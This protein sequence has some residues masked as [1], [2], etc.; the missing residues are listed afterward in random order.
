MATTDNYSNYLRD[1]VNDLVFGATSYTKPTTTRFTLLTVMATA[2]GGGTVAPGYSPLSFTN[3]SSNWPAS[4]SR[5]KASAA[6]MNFGN[7]SAGTTTIVGVMEDDAGSPPN[8]LT[9]EEL[10]AAILV[11]NG[12]NFL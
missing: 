12:D 7:N 6:D 1:K 8:L 4:A 3:N 5:L 11:N 9:F 10:N 2:S